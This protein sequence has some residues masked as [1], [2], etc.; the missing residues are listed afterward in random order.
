MQLLDE[1]STKAAGHHDTTWVVGSF[2]YVISI[3]PAM[4]TAWIAMGLS[5]H[6]EKVILAAALWV[7]HIQY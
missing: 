3:T 5:F 7:A 6:M 2:F 4:G 1:A